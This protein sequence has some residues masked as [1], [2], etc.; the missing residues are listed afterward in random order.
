MLDVILPLLTTAKLGDVFR[1]ID[2]QLCE[3]HRVHFPV[4][5]VLITYTRDRR[6]MLVSVLKETVKAG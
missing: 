6:D 5:G 3:V 4:W 2:H 1:D